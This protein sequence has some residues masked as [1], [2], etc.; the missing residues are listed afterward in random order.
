MG[1][2]RW[3]QIFIFKPRQGVV[4]IFLR[5][6]IMLQQK[7]DEI[8]ADS[9]WVIILT[10]MVLIWMNTGSVKIEKFCGFCLFVCLVFFCLNDSNWK[11][12][13]DGSKIHESIKESYIGNCWRVAGN[14][15]ITLLI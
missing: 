12:H 14:G 13:L 8:N 4:S 10:K 6:G 1:I 9:N 2:W 15:E 7:K 3:N 5:L 11:S